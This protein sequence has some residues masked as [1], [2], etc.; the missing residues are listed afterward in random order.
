MMSQLGSLLACR[1]GVVELGYE[2]AVGGAGGGEVLVAFA[3]LEAQVGG[4]LF[5]VGDFLVQGVDVG[6]CA[7][8]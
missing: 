3:E 8:P 6:G 2:L 7:E 1:G 5:E 4:L